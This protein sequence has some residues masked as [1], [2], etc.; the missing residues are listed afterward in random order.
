MLVWPGGYSNSASAKAVRLEGDQFTGFLPRKM[1]PS[2][3]ILPNTC[4]PRADH[5][6]GRRRIRRN[7]RCSGGDGC[8]G[9]ER[10]AE[11]AGKRL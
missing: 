3:N 9:G 2:V 6:A 4:P 1:C 11:T 7:N 8:S 5:P 10:R